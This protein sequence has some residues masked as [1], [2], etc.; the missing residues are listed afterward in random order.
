MRPQRG[1]HR[2]AGLRAERRGA[3]AQR[4]AQWRCEVR[5]AALTGR[6]FC[7]AVGPWDVSIGALPTCL[8]PG[9]GFESGG[10]R[11]GARLGVGDGGRGQIAQVLVDNVC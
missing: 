6:R 3:V 10:E 2:P 4:F 7:C 11:A 8:V 9:Q 1:S 5:G